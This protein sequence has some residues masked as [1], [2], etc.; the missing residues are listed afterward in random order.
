MKI[1]CTGGCG[2]VGSVLVP[3]LLEK[4]HRVVVFDIQWF[5]NHLH[6]HPNLEIIKGDIRDTDSIPMEVDSI[7]HLAGI[8]NDPCGELDPKLSWE[9]NALATTQLA[10]KAA[11]HGVRQFIYAS[12][13]S[14]YGIKSE[15]RVTEDLLCVPLTEYNKT[16]MV[17][18][19]VLLSYA[20]QM[21]VQIL[22]P[23]TVCGYSPRMRL[24][25]V[26]NNF[27]MQAL[28]R[29]KINV[30]GGDQMRPHIHIDDM[31]DAYL[32]MLDKPGRVGV[33]NAAFENL[34]VMKIAEMVSSVNG[35]T[36]MKNESDDPRS[37]RIYSGK[38]MKAG[39][40]SRFSVKHAITDILKAALYRGLRDED[41]Y[42]NLKAMPR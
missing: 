15:I 21:S 8:A 28:T 37:Y 24:D 19:R 29:H 20:R 17:A 32:F 35:S 22:R 25:V 1:L 23:G 33:F 38:L 26:V 10:E 2:Y 12:S 18:E 42:Y 5:G 11:R 41:Q 30:L 34:S 14:V 3:K 9:V 27:V 31:T 40:H 36:I 16:K 39:F 4:N 13:G 7:I 6:P